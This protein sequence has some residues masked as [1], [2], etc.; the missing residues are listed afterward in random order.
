MKIYHS[1]AEILYFLEKNISGSKKS[2]SSIFSDSEVGK[3]VF[4]RIFRKSWFRWKN[5]DFLQKCKNWEMY[6]SYHPN[7]FFWWKYKSWGLKYT[8]CDMYICIFLKI[9]LLE[10]MSFVGAVGGWRDFDTIL[11]ATW[12]K[13]LIR[14]E[15]WES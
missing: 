4:L 3:N 8:F 15:F 6:S 2:F 13:K 11:I 5:H 12:S 10:K 9:P 14:S 7:S 1:G